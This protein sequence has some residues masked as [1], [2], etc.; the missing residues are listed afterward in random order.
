MR[1]TASLR[2]LANETDLHVHNLIQP[3]FV[4]DGEGD[5]EPIESMPGISRLTIPLLI[6]ECRELLALGIP[7]VALFPKLDDSLKSDDG[8]EALNPGTLIL[9]TIRE[10]KAAVPE[11]AIIT[12]LALDPYTVHGHDGL[13][14]VQAGDLINDATVE[15][16]AEMAVLAAEA[17]VD[18]VAPSDMMDGRVG[19]IRVAL[20]ENGFEKTA[21]MAYSAK[22]ASAFYGPFRDAVGSASSAGT[23]HLDKRTYQLNPG[24]RREALIE[25]AL[26]EE[27]GADVLM[28]KPAGPYLDII[29]EVREETELPLAAYQVSGEY[30]QLQAAAERGWLD[31]ERCR[32]ESLLAIRRAGADMILTY[33]AKAYALSVANA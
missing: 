9:R 3:I 28:V 31:L 19:A 14:D 1:R 30:A 33:F 17:G 22:F 8:R 32:D 27:E 11:M 13:F 5:A 12:D 25:V 7:A 23:H 24:N 2:A 18:F 15:I 20:D 16:L 21:V 6:E 26:D 29:R 10:L 4:I